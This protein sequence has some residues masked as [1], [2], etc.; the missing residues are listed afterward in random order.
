MVSNRLTPEAILDGGQP[1][2]FPESVVDFFRGKIGKPPFGFPK[3][4][5]AIVLRDRKK[6]KAGAAPAP[7]KLGDVRRDLEGK[8]RREP[9]HR[10]LL[11]YLMYPQVFLDYDRERTNHSEVEVVPT[12][13]FLFG[14]EPGE[15]IAVEI[16]K[17]KRIILKLLAV[18]Q[19]GPDGMRKLVFEVNGVA[20]EIEI[21]D[22][23]FTKKLVSRRKADPADLHQL[24]A[25]MQGLVAEVRASPGKAVEQ[26][27]TLFVLEAMKMQVNVTAPI[28]RVVKEVF[29][30]KGAKVEQGD[31]LLTFE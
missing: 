21:E 20:R 3:K 6:E 11:S 8:I 7:I 1:L 28:A 27:E 24:A 17:G 10:E 30:E 5:R 18:G 16:E 25:S 29:V 15:E 12:K 31:L 2:S 4:L 23:S 13:N 19:P 22:R 9:T 26:G 14:M